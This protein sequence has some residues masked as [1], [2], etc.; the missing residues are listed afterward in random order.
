V[1]IDSA[2]KAHRSCGHCT[3]A[4]PRAASAYGDAHAGAGTTLQLVVDNGDFVYY[5]DGIAA[6]DLSERRHAKF[7]SEV[8]TID[9]APPPIAIFID[10]FE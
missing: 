10:G 7:R 4:I 8:V 2:G 9:L 5:A 1:L 6:K 3:I